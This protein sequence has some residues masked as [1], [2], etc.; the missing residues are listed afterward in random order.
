MPSSAPSPRAQSHASN[1]LLQNVG[2]FEVTAD[3]AIWTAAAGDARL[4]VALKQVSSAEW[5]DGGRACALWLRDKSGVLTR[6]D[7]FKLAE[8]DRLSSVLRGAGIT[9]DKASLAVSGRNWGTWGLNGE[10]R[11]A[12]RAICP[13]YMH[14]WRAI[15]CFT[16]L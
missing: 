12:A 8:F 11:A 4:A 15:H 13:I 14:V 9:L 6:F 1:P 7:G 3:A 5:L 16:R 10:K 2:R